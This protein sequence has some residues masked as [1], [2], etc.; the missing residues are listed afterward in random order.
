MATFS[1]QWRFFP[2]CGVPAPAVAFAALL[3][4]GFQDKAMHM[5]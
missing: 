2:A 5:P 1:V 3:K 4:M